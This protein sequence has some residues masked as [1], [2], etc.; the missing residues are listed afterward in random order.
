MTKWVADSIDGVNLLTHEETLRP[1][2]DAL[3]PTGGVLLDVGANVGLW[4]VLL[5]RRASRVIAVEPSAETAAM[6]RQN[7]QL[8]NLGAVTE[9]LE[10]AAWDENTTLS[11][12]NPTGQPRSG[13]M[14]VV[15]DPD[16]TIPGRRLDDVLRADRIDLV[17]IDT[18]GA[19]LHVLRGMQ[20]HLARCRPVLFLE[21]SHVLP[22]GYALT[23]LTDLLDDL[24]YSWEWA[25]SWQGD[26]IHMFCRP[27]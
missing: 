3:F 5:G 10:I 16:G 6:L 7:L 24:N 19:D 20:E 2:V 4:S 21:S 13:W 9:V 23:E 18:E 1:A 14:R 17:K 27:A 25:P 11:L 8:N 12:V 22:Y 26:I 15:P